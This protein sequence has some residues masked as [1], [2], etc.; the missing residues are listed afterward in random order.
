MIIFY[1]NISSDLAKSG[2][3]DQDNSDNTS[4]TYVAEESIAGFGDYDYDYYDD[5]EVETEPE[6][7]PDSAS[8]SEPEPYAEGTGSQTT[9]DENEGIW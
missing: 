9:L 5:E 4:I 2:L 7:D 6:E 1:T 8:E 3:G